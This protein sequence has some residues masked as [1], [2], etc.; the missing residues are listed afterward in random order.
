M[1]FELNKNLFKVTHE[2]KEGY[3]IIDEISVSKE[4]KPYRG[5]ISGN[6]YIKQ[7]G[8]IQAGDKIIASTFPLGDLPQFV[9]QNKNSEDELEAVVKEYI[10]MNSNK[11]WDNNEDYYNPKNRE[12]YSFK[13]GWNKHAEKYK[14]T[15]E[16]IK[17]AI[18]LAREADS[19]D[20]VVDLPIVLNYPNVDNSDLQI[21]WTEEE[22][23]QFLQQPKEITEIEFEHIWE[24][25]KGITGDNFT[26]V[27]IKQPD[28][29]FDAWLALK[30]TKSIKY[31]NGLLII[32][33]VKYG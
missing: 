16:D 22:I 33:N 6:I 26:D 14:F 32:K 7:K 15:E 17:K 2:G 4:G 13:D 8:V 11:E 24:N 25:Q 3:V 10:G 29:E 23:I 20:G 21:K 30:I 12:Y 28:G 1:K 5:S 9:I 31:P 18:Q 19:I 27:A